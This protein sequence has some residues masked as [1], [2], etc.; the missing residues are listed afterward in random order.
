[1][2]ERIAFRWLIV[3]LIAYVVISF[4]VLAYLDTVDLPPWRLPMVIHG[5]RGPALLVR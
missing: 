5:G 2:T 3:G 4:A 1:M